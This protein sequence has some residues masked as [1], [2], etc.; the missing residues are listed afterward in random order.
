MDAAKSIREVAESIRKNLP[1]QM[2][3]KGPSRFR[4]TSSSRCGS[5]TYSYVHEAST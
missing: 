5:P 1:K 4:K 3:Q 2:K